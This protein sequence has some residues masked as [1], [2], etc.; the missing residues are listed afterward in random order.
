MGGYLAVCFFL[1]LF[2]LGPCR[3]DVFLSMFMMP[4]TIHCYYGRGFNGT[5]LLL[6]MNCYN[7]DNYM[8]L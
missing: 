3:H 7:A 4:D 5:W 2:F 6:Y 1:L 8:L